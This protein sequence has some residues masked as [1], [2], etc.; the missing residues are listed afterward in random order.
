MQ[1]WSSQDAYLDKMLRPCDMQ[2]Y[3]AAGLLPYKKGSDGEL[4]FLMAKERPWNSFINDYDPLSMNIIGGRRGPSTQEWIPQVSGTR[5]FLEILGPLDGL[6]KPHEICGQAQGG[7]MLWFPRGRY[8]LSIFEASDISFPDDIGHRFAK[9]REVN[10]LEPFP[11]GPRG[12]VKWAKQIEGL[13]WVSAKDLM[14]K[15][16]DISDLVENVM[17]VERFMDFLKDTLDMEAILDPEKGEV[18]DATELEMLFDSSLER[19][20]KGKEAK[21]SGG[22]KDGDGKGD[23]HKGHYGEGKGNDFKG[24]GKSKGYGPKGKGKDGFKGGGK[25]FK[26]KGGPKGGKGF[27]PPGKSNGM[28]FQWGAPQQQVPM[29]Q[30]Q[31]G[32]PA[33]PSPN[34]YGEMQRQLVGEQLYALVQPMAPTAFIAQKIT[35]MLLE[36]PQSEYMPLVN[37]Q[38]ELRERVEEAVQVL[39]QN[40]LVA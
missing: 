31:M 22:G 20:G 18:M 8:A 9:W 21:G 6:P 12:S 29:Y 3:A 34:Q 17:N 30:Y 11:S 10:P 33:P 40:G 7:F 24:K 1:T 4:Q 38:V 15:S 32:G 14:S 28:P 37:D 36:L 25:D 27:G 39:A 26:G 13:D 5:I 2:G 35:G 23:G 16:V 19:K